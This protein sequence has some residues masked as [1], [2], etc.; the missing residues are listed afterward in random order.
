MSDSPLIQ[1]D[2]TV[3][4][5]GSASE[6]A[7]SDEATEAAIATAANALAPSRDRPHVAPDWL[8][9]IERESTSSG[10]APYR[11]AGATGREL[12]LRWPIAKEADVGSSALSIGKLMAIG[13]TIGAG[14][15]AAA[16][17]ILRAALCAAFAIAFGAG[18]GSMRAGL[19]GITD[20]RIDRAWLEVSTRGT[21]H[22]AGRPHVLASSS[23]VVIDKARR[24][25]GG[26]IA[27]EAI[28]SVH[29]AEVVE[30][31]YLL[32]QLEAMLE[33]GSSRRLLATPERDLANALAELIGRELKIP[34]SLHVRPP[35]S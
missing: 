16:G 2:E 23:G 7:P 9:I 25:L 26:R 19:R 4:E 20:V 29:V 21:R 17:E 11:A 10:G 28:R 3:T 5:A 33:D 18:M 15:A 34:M 12:V 24:D 30:E 6:A 8:Q 13:L 14:V 32:Y 22:G 31:D 27:R 1:P 35:S